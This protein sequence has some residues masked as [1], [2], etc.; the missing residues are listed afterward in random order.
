[1]ESEA[2]TLPPHIAID[3][4]AA[5][6]DCFVQQGSVTFFSDR[7]RRTW[8]PPPAKLVIA[9]I[10]EHYHVEIFADD[11][12]LFALAV[13]ARGISQLLFQMPGAEFQRAPHQKFDR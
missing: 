11:R 2:G 6:R 5:C 13:Q 7:E 1:M 4:L 3:N 12:F 10:R 9:A 8:D